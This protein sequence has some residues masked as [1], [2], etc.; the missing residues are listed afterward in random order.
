MAQQIQGLNILVHVGE[1][2]LGAQ[3]NCTLS[4]EADSIDVSN[5]NSFGWSDFIPG[6][7]NWSISCDG[8]F[9]TDDAGQ[10]ALMDAYI[11]STFVDIEMKN[12]EETIYYK[13]KAMI[14]SLELDAPYDDVFAYSV[15]FTGKG[16]LANAKAGNQ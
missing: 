7:K 15:E 5:K 13:G 16:A 10:K 14:T 4:L 8:Q 6:T 3:K 2:V 1:T 11:N 9:I 12:E